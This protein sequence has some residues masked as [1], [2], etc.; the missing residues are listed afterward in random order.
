MKKIFFITT[1]I[2]SFSFIFP[3]LSFA[4][5]N[6]NHT[7]I[8]EAEGRVLFEKLQSKEL[9]CENLSDENFESLGE[10]FMGNM[11]KEQH[12]TMNNMM[13][14]M[15]GKENEEKMHIALGKR[16][17][18]CEPDAPMPQNMMSIMMG[19]WSN[20]SMLKLFNN[21]FSMM[22]LGFTPF[23]WFGFIFMILFWVL[24]IAGIVALI[25]WLT[26]QSKIENKKEKSATDILKIRYAKGEID[27]KE[28]KE[29]SQE[30]KN[31]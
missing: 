13:I 6:D 30:I 24:I 21:P 2:F 23:A 16:M 1:F 19:N 5:N 29:K 11:A 27:K 26:D 4:Q 3:I 28:F 25:K 17:S 18:N 14:Q 9:I 8:E 20:P 31:L 7:A 22:N 12:E 10:Y 15:M